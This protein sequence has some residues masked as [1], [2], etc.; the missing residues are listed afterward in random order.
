MAKFEK[1]CYSSGWTVFRRLERW[2]VCKT[3]RSRCPQVGPCRQRERAHEEGFRTHACFTA[4]DHLEKAV[5]WSGYG[6]G[7]W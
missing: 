6:Y 4:K 2:K 5:D 1:C 3:I 7:Y